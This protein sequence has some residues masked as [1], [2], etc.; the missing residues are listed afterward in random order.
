[1]VGLM[2]GSPEDF[3]RI[4]HRG[5]QNVAKAAQEVG[6]KL[7]HFSAIGADVSSDIAYFKTKGLGEEAVLAE[8]PKSTIVRPSL[9][10]G[11]RD[12]FFSKFATMSSFMPFL[13]VFAG[14]TTKFQP[15]YVGD[16]ASLVE[17]ISRNDPAVRSIVDGKT[18]E[19]GGP[20]VFTYYEMMQIV[21]KC[22]NRYR[23]ILSLPYA[24]GTAQGFF[25]EKLPENIFT[26]SRDQVKQLKLDNIVR[27]HDPS[28]KDLV[29][30]YTG[31]KLASVHDI[32]PTYL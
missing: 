29:E 4:Q 10:F 3:D 17:I 23:P 32:L 12:G 2:Y 22:K 15:V 6:A 9:V 5:A 26:L 21:L 31:R 28:F 1:L 24:F 20:H 7:I 11:P 13:P 8:N 19:A 30:E 25:M 18:I 16:L 27:S 14:G